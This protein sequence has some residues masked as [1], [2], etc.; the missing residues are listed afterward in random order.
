ME[1]GDKKKTLSLGSGKL[2]LGGVSADQGAPASPRAPHNARQAPH[3]AE[4]AGS[5]R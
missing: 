1:K 2:T 3:A 5:M 4:I